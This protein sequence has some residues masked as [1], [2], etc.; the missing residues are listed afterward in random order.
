MTEVVH[1]VETVIHSRPT[2]H[3]AG[4]MR[5]IVTEVQAMIDHTG[6]SHRH[7]CSCL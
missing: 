6:T 2:G 3:I 4:I 5:A 1:Q 7:T